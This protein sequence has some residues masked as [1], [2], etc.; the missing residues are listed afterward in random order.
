[1]VITGGAYGLDKDTKVKIGPAESDDDAK[2]K[3]GK[4]GGDD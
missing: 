4:S 1:M 3:A 2:P